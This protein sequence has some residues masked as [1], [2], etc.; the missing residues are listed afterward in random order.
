[1]DPLVSYPEM[2][3]HSKTS[4]N[5]PGQPRLSHSHPISAQYQPSPVTLPATFPARAS[6]NSSRCFRAK[7]SITSRVDFSRKSSSSNMEAWI[8][9]LRATWANHGRGLVKDVLHIGIKIY[10]AIRCYNLTR[11]YDVWLAYIT[12]Q[13]HG[14]IHVV[15]HTYKW[16]LLHQW[17]IM[18][19]RVSLQLSPIECHTLLMEL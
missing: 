18:K 15:F 6:N 4:Q 13:N 3:S 1:M 9:I 19:M 14:M 11:R 8:E 5:H 10:D 16:G 2:K 12:C 17:F 7:L